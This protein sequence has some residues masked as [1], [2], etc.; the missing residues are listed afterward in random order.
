VVSAGDA[1]AQIVVGNPWGNAPMNVYIGMSGG[2]A[3]AVFLN[4]STNA[5]AT[6]LLGNG[7]GLTN[8]FLIMG[9]SDM[10]FLIVVGGLAPRFDVCGTSVFSLSFNGHFLDVSGNGGVDFVF[11]GTGDSWAYGGEGNDTVQTFSPVGNAF[12]ENGNDRVF[13]TSAVSS[14]RLFGQA[15]DDCL[16]DSGNAHNA[17][18]CGGHNVHDYFVSPATG[19]LGCEVVV[20]GC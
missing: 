10:D 13:G 5:C 18:D 19:A 12:G 1:Q 2:V 15:G 8:D 7:S 20:G 11:N 3:K 14:D 16:E 4:R 17:F 6:S 9:G